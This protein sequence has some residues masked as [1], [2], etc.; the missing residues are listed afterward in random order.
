MLHLNMHILKISLDFLT[1]N[2]ANK[3]GIT[4][5]LVYIPTHLSVEADYLS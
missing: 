5:I 3:N 2:L 1:F 4:L